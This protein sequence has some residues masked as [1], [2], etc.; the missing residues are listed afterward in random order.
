MLS[1]VV[2]RTLVP[3]FLVF[4]PLLSG[5]QL[6]AALLVLLGHSD[7]RAA[8]GVVPPMVAGAFLAVTGVLLIADL[9]QP[10]RFHYLITRGSWDSWLVKGAYVLGAFA[11]LCGLWWVGGLVESST[12]VEIVSIPT[13]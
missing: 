7:V 8:V 3:I 6:V 13:A 1:G 5:G 12:L 9:K 11:A 4:M 10:T 2:L